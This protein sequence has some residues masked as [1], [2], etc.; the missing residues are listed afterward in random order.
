[1]TRLILYSTVCG[2]PVSFDGD[3][4]AEEETFRSMIRVGWAKEDPLFGGSSRGSSSRMPEQMRWFDALQRMTTSPN[5]RR[6]GRQAVDIADELPASA[7]RRSSS[8]R[9][10]LTT[11]DAVEVA[12]RIPGAQL[13]ELDSA[14]HPARR[15][16]GMGDVRG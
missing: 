13:V 2:R 12:G 16:G 14:N 8:D 6:L 1:V 5:R 7:R 4:L 9:R 11:F 10:S 15:R 3:A